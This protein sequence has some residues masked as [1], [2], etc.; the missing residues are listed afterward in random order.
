MYIASDEKHHYFRDDEGYYK[1]SASVPIP[2]T[3]LRRM[4]ELTARREKPG[5]SGIPVQFDGDKVVHRKRDQK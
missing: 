5:H 2:S 1:L 3:M 4:E